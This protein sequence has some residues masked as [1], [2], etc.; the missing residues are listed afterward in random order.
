MPN[1]Q[2]TKTPM[3]TRT[4]EERKKD[5]GEVAIGYTEEMAINE[6]QRCLDCKN[7]PCA[8]GCPV[9][10]RIP[11][12]IKELKNGD[13]EGAYRVISR[14]SSL[15]AVCGRVCPQETQCEAKCVSAV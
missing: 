11:D 8:S 7:M 3:P 13:V 4:P 1:M 10:I 12:F 2:T 9:G 6:A 5:F 15:P 14:A